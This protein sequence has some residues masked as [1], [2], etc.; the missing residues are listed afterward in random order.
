VEL[1]TGT[2]T[3]LFTDVEG[4]TRLWELFPRAMQAALAVHDALLRGSVEAR[5]GSIVKTTGDGV[6]AV[7]A[8]ARDALDAAVI[9]QHELTSAEW[10]DTEPLKV[11]IGV[12]TGEA[13]LRDGDYFGS[14]VN[15]AARLMSIAHGGQIVLSSS[16]ASLIDATAV[17][18]RDLGEHRLVGLSRPERVWQVCVPGLARDF[19]PL[20]SVD[21]TPGNL[22][23][24]MTSFVGREALVADVAERV[25]SQPLVT[26]TGVGGVGK[27]R[28]ALEVA[29]R[30][31]GDVPDGAW[32]CELA[33]LSD[34]DAIWETVASALR[35]TRVP[36]R[37]VDELVVEYLR[38][39]QLVLVVDNCEHL[40]DAVAA[41]VQ[42]IAERCPGVAV[43]ATSREGLGLPGE[44]IMA[45]RSLGIPPEDAAG[46]ALSQ[47]ESMVLFCDRARSVRSDFRPSAHDEAA[48]AVVC[49]RL[50]G[51]PLAIELAAAR[52]RSLRPDD[53]VDRLDQ[54]FKLLTRGSRA[55]LER[56]QTLRNTIDWSYEL[57]DDGERRALNRVS[58]FASGCDLQAAEAVVGDEELD[59]LDVV[60]VIGQL[61]D[62]SLVLA[63]TDD[64]GRLRYRLLETVRQYAQEQLETSGEAATIRRRHADHFLAVAET[65]GAGLRSPD[66]LRWAR[67]AR[68]EIDN[69]RTALDWAVE[70]TAPEHALRLVRALALTRTTV[71]DITSGWTELAL[72][73]PGATDDRLYPDVASLAVQSA[74]ARGDLAGA[75]Q[76]VVMVAEAEARLGPGSATA[77]SGPASM[78]YL[79]GDMDLARAKDQEWVDRAR[80]EHDACELSNAL[81]ALSMV[82]GA[83]GDHSSDVE[84]AEEALAVARASGVPSALALALGLLP[85]AVL[86]DDPERALELLDEAIA[87]SAEVGNPFLAAM[88]V[89][90]KGVYHDSNGDWNLALDEVNEAIELLSQLGIVTAMVGG[91]LGV[92][93]VA[94]AGLGHLEPGAITLG[95]SYRYAPGAHQR[96]EQLRDEAAATLIDQ[97]GQASYDALYA[98]GTELNP[99][100]A[101]TVLTTA[102]AVVSSS[103]AS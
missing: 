53:I 51:I 70:T 46:D 81:I 1:P 35:V 9:V 101:M 25:R 103:T 21:A 76:Y 41:L 82:H 75:D 3:F 94:L 22:P 4:S 92:A 47:A 44:Q 13:E 24:P 100:E 20:R 23:R 56:H 62:K 50:D 33:P 80:R 68:R 54:R 71:G 72:T 17:E 49:R 48:I 39:K 61:V 14:E 99:E 42:T 95:A 40:L 64:D 83:L 84:S 67:V 102:L 57:L 73:V 45:V 91:V 58:V 10:S 74:L 36:G 52:L 98:R 28:L 38:S 96:A 37:G 32:L 5:G 93:A 87:L 15:R 30:I 7:F 77:C 66:Q 63:E 29:A 85:W 97:L 19:P 55:A 60:D 12:H 26:L 89:T 90:G 88:A 31:A 16:T 59:A 11:R 18:L 43:L 8:S 34:P 2:V 6:L 78:A 27:T 65:V 69:L 79:S 86:A